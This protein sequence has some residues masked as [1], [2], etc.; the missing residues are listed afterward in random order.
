MT[1]SKVT[2]RT[3]VNITVEGWYY[4]GMFAFVVAGAMIRDINLL[5]IMAGM[6][7][8]P[9]F[10]S[11]YASMRSLRRIE[12]NRRYPSLVSVNEPLFVEVTA[13]K[14]KGNPHAFATVVQDRICREGVKNRLATETQLYFPAIRS[15]SS[16]D[17][18][19]RVTLQN[20]GRYN[21]GVMKVST[22][23]PL[24][25]IQ[26]T[27][28]FD[29]DAFV[30][31]SPKI[32]SLST[33]WSRHLEFKNDGGQKSARR[34]GN[35]EGDFYGMREY[36]T[37]DSLNRIHWRTSAKR[38]KLTVRQFEQRVNQDLVVIL[39]LWSPDPQPDR[40]HVE[41]AISFAATL[42]VEH[43]KQGATHVVFA[44][45]SRNPFDLSG[46]ASPVF[47]QELMERLAMVEV[48]GDDPLPKVLAEVLPLASSNAK[49]VLV[50][51]RE[52]DLNDTNVFAEVL[53][54]T[55]IRQGLGEIV[56]V[57]SSADEFAE[58]FQSERRSGLTTMPKEPSSSQS[59]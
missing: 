24:G 36:R 53:K 29:Q 49:I 5:Y 16:E 59:P 9:L 17:A 42:M 56:R 26:V 39:D 21:L 15:G 35:A 38:N 31:V 12:V 10:F 52:R 27:K 13:S 58:W 23:M 50:S 7:L 1:S 18:S 2:R 55:A 30:L 48:A 22:S 3:N 11:W 46:M 34:R 4:I 28:T 8:G 51:T 6:M 45:A 41:E 43:C 44:S 33:A 37:G 57:D 25:L 47:R 19:Y 40:Q 54:N 20:R 32:G 14:P